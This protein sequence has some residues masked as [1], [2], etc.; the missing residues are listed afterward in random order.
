MNQ[1]PGRLWRNYFLLIDRTEEVKLAFSKTQQRNASTQYMNDD[2]YNLSLFRYLYKFS[3]LCVVLKNGKQ[4]GWDYGGMQ[5]RLLGDESRVCLVDPDLPHQVVVTCFPHQFVRPGCRIILNWQFAP[6]WWFN[7]NWR[8]GIWFK[9]AACE[10]KTA[11]SFW[12]GR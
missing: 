6:V 4:N 11:H 8:N 1:D 12:E 5:L 3:Q 7:K 9:Y 10:N 2:L